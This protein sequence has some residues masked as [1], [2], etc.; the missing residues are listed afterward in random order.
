ME[1]LYI[2]IREL[3]DKTI[4]KYNQRNEENGGYAWGS[5]PVIQRLI[6]AKNVLEEVLNYFEKQQTKNEKNI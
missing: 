5:D 4:N 1:E 3:Y 2:K 6:G